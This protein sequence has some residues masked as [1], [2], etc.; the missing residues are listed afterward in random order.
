MAKQKWQKISD[1]CVRHIWKCNNE[2]CPDKG[3]RDKGSSIATV[4]PDWYERNGTPACFAC[5]RDM[6]YVKTVINLKVEEIE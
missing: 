5:D 2:Y 4:N 1:D 3:S 6:V